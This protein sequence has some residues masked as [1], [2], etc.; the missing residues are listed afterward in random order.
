M[1][2]RQRSVL[3]SS[4]Q[5]YPDA[6]HAIPPMFRGVVSSVEWCRPSR[7]STRICIGIVTALQLR[8]AVARPPSAR[9]GCPGGAGG[10][11]LR[12]HAQQP[13]ERGRFAKLVW[14]Q[15]SPVV[16]PIVSDPLPSLADLQRR[17]RGS[18]TTYGQL[19]PRQAA[20][21][22]VRICRPLPKRLPS[23]CLG[24]CAPAS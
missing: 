15:L 12:T 1:R 21:A 16:G 20:E 19:P 6:H 11:A 22:T 8:R 23:G 7:L 3:E 14:V 17:D 5:V 2:S 4:C 10:A 9:F 13:R 24:R 18:Y